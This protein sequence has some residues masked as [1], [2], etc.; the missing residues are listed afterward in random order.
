M[1]VCCYK[2]DFILLL[3]PQQ[4]RITNLSLGLSLLCLGVSTTKDTGTT[5]G[6]ETDLLTWRG[7]TGS[8]SRVTNVLMVT[9]TVRMF[10]GVHRHT[11]NLRPAVSLLLV[12][13]ERGSGFEHR[14]IDA[15]TSCDDTDDGTGCGRDSLTSTG[16]KLYHGLLAV[17]GVTDNDA[18]SSGGTS[19]RTTVGHLVFQHGDDGTFWALADGKDVSDSELSGTTTVDELASVETFDGNHKLLV[20]LV[21]V[22]ITEAY[23][24]ERSTT[25]R[26]VDDFLDQTLH[27]TVTF[28]IV[29]GAKLGSSLSV[30]GLRGEDS[31]TTFTLTSYD[32]SHL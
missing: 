8:S 26:I 7:V 29:E 5:G 23:F 14:L 13:V 19:D 15:T 3:S 32:T 9:T 18:G 2:I 22:R 27:V 20:D 6:D 16:R 12:L 4:E 25:T 28:S 21:S 31:S 11:T 17:L 10:D 1:L 24:G 30:L